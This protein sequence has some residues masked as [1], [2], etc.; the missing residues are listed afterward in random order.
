M[1]MLMSTNCK[2]IRKKKKQL[3]AYNI[4]IGYELTIFTTFYNGAFSI[5]SKNDL[6][7][8]NLLLATVPSLAKKSSYSQNFKSKSTMHTESLY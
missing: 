5:A 1:I 3:M 4:M 6:E 2:K 7:D 8:Q